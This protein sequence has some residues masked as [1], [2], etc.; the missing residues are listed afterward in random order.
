MVVQPAQLRDAIAVMLAEMEAHAVTA[1]TTQEIEALVRS[2]AAVA[3]VMS[4]EFDVEAGLLH[5]SGSIEGVPMLLFDD[6][7]D[8]PNES[9]WV[10]DGHCIR[11]APACDSRTLRDTLTAM[12]SRLSRKQG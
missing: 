9:G 4:S 7:F 3:C 5:W 12:L 2:G 10:W 8:H 6:E 11:L 1:T